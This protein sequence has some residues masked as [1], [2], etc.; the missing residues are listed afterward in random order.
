V[1]SRAFRVSLLL[2]G[3][4]LTALVYQIA[5]MRE[6]RLVFGFSTASSAAVVAIFMGGLG[7]G[8][9]LLGRRADMTPRPLAFYG[10]LELAIAA[11]AAATPVLLWL[12]RAAYVAAGGSLRLGI[13][14][15]TLARLLLSSLVLAV[16]TVLMGGTLPAAARAVETDRDSARRLLALLYG[17]N[18][19]GAV[20]GTLLSTFFL[21]ERLGTRETLWASCA[22]NALVGLAALLLSKS[23]PAAVGAV[24]VEPQPAPAP[25]TIP[26][27]IAAPAPRLGDGGKKKK[28]ERRGQ[29]RP[30]SPASPPA[31]RAAGPPARFVLGA[32]AVT[33]FAFTLMELVWYRMLAPLLGGSTYTFGLILAVALAGIGAGS[34]A[35]S[36]RERPGTLAGFATTCA[37]EAALLAFP[38]GLGDSV[39]VLASRLRPEGAFGFGSLVSGWTAVAALVVFPAAFVAGVQFPI[40][41]SLLGR[42]REKVGTHVG[43][44]YAWNTAGAIVGSLAG[45]FGLLPLLSATGTWVFVTLLL[46]A[47]AVAALVLSRG[48]REEPRGRWWIPAGAA[49]ASVALVTTTGPTAAWRHSPIGAGRVHLSKVSGNRLEE[50]LRDQRRR[51]FWQADGVESSVAMTT[52]SGG[53]AF[54]V[55]GKIDGNTRTDAP[56]QVMGGLIGAALHR[57]PRRALVIGLGTGSTAGWLA[58]V[59][60][61]ERVDV[62]ELE[63]AILRVAEASAPVN[64]NVLA[65]PKVRITIGDARE[66]LLTSRDSYDVIFSEPSNPYRA[67]ISSLFTEEFYRA[68]R[69]RLAPGGI[70]L[71]WLQS[72]EVDSE[73]VRAV[74]ETLGSAF[75]AIESWFA[76]YHDLILAASAAPVAYDAD[77]LRARL[78]QEPY[79][80]AL[81]AAWATA[82]LEGFLSHFVARASFVPALFGVGRAPRNTDDR[83]VI[84]FA[85]ARSL[86]RDT[87]FDLDKARSL[88]RERGEDTP[89]FARGTPDREMVRRLRISTITANGVVG[90]ARSGMTPEELL[91]SETQKDFL[92]GHLEKV[93]DLWRERPWEPVGSVE[94]A[95]V[96]QAL[97]DAGDEAAVRY[98]GRLG[99]EQPVEAGILLGQLRWRQGRFAEATDLFEKAYA[100]Y[101]EDPWPLLSVMNRSFTI[102]ADLAG[103][104]RRYAERLD[105]ALAQ[106]F[107]V[108]LLNEERL[109][110][111]YKVATYLDQSKLEDA[112]AAL[113]P[114]M[115]WR[116]GLLSRRARLYE[117]TRNPR[118][119]L[120]RRELDEFLKHESKSD[121]P[122]APE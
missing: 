102:A 113:E 122:A 105:S 7:V 87:A 121:T 2:F 36:G 26:E 43:L 21:L 11:S 22:V 116:K 6:L 15:G 114:H 23:I 73:T 54:V 28:E 90:Q 42:G 91:Q 74:Y 77:L 44:A 95:V 85:F 8:S 67:G 112:V 25:A 68:A 40:L 119:A 31:R 83:N 32:A 97:A 10:A 1:T 76:G 103:R 20:A 34:L 35:R 45:G 89:V 53:L 79:R 19:L 118:A 120:A 78:S 106:P 30:V 107:A 56:T 18:T 109:Q 61:I 13:L 5:W 27:R 98:I 62:V 96:S 80:S 49:A 12:V 47:L 115:P 24:A 37:V 60:S 50:W 16:P 55:N 39:A 110:T 71:Q 41:I 92:E 99:G 88:A 3:S 84:E 81:S 38:Y 17:S 82:G 100:R 14:G 59:P 48:R 69:A 9:W 52:T 86:G 29:R 64:R 117:S 33:G 51:T 70:F 58:A 94:L 111:R 66:Y 101:R 104:D 63:P 108:L 75:P 57:E 93:L 46:A 72:Y 65:S 4:G